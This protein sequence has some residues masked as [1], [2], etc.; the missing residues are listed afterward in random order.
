MWAIQQ[1]DVIVE[2]PGRILASND[3]NVRRLDLRTGASRIV[4]RGHQP[5][6]WIMEHLQRHRAF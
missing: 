5:S 2:A 4:F 6:P 1:W 3:V